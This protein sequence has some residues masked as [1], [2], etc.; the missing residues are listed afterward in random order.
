MVELRLTTWERV[1]LRQCVPREAPLS[2]IGQ[3]LRILDALD[4]DEAEL[5]NQ[6]VGRAD[7]V[8]YT[9]YRRPR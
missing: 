5:R 2:E 4:L 7:F 3:L 6:D 9:G 1:E 8:V